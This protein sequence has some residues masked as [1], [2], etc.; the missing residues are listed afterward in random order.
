M[1]RYNFEE[2][3]SAYIDGELSQEDKRKFQ[4]LINNDEN[5]KKRYNE[6]NQIV[7]NLTSLPKLETDDN[8]INSLNQKIDNYEK[9]N[10]SMFEKLKRYFISNSKQDR[11]RTAAIR[12]A[13]GIVMS[14]AAFLMVFYLSSN[15]SNAN[16]SI[17]SNPSDLDDEIY[18]SDIDSTDS[19]Q[20]EDEIQLTK[21]LDERE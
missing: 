6:M 3:I 16:S 2:H 11:I 19:E 18:Y 14:C 13:M 9:L 1:D 20:Y 17:V 10:I 15:N 7:S 5:C 4:E 8:F 12:P 21:G